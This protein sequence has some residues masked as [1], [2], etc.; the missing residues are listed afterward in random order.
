[1]SWTG[2]VGFDRRWFGIALFVVVL[3]STSSA[4]GQ[5]TFDPYNPSTGQYQEFVTPVYPSNLALPGQAR[6]YYE[7]NRQSAVGN[8]V[9]AASAFERFL[10]DGLEDRFSAATSSLNDFTRPRGVAGTPYYAASR[11]LDRGAGGMSEADRAFFAVRRERERRYFEAIREKDPT[12]RARLLRRVNEPID[13]KDIVADASSGSEPSS[14]ATSDRNPNASGS[15]IRIARNREPNR[16]A[17]RETAALGAP[18][19]R[20]LGRAPLRMPY[21]GEPL[22]PPAA[23][24]PPARGVETAVDP[25]TTS[26]AAITPAPPSR[27]SD[28]SNGPIPPARRRLSS[29]PDRRPLLP[30]ERVDSG[31]GEPAGN[32]R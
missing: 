11:S 2:S 21:A 28:R 29:G 3:A 26:P 10:N 1:M 32:P 23:P 4:F 12:K 30:S 16:P 5:S 25:S 7:L 8:K 31:R 19:E 9:S 18:P 15:G 17:S 27:S 24:M 22:D 20:P 13:P 14:T 6:Q